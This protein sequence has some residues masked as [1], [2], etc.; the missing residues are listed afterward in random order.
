MQKF[1]VRRHQISVKKKTNYKI[2]FSKRTILAICRTQLPI[3]PYTTL[4][5]LNI[6]QCDYLVFFGLTGPIYKNNISVSEYEYESN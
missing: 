4:K 3:M 5:Y 2:Y 1:R 6:H